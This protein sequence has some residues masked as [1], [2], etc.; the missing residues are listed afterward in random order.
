M[1]PQ[2]L[3]SMVPMHPPRDDPCSQNQTYHLP[4]PGLTAAEAYLGSN[5]YQWEWMAFENWEVTQA[6]ALNE[7]PGHGLP[8]DGQ[9]PISA[10]NRTYSLAQFGLCRP[11]R[12]HSL[13]F[14][15]L[16]GQAGF[17]TIGCSFSF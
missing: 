11:V 13:A 15:G 4:V 12:L 16:S 3:H 5:L 8:A 9:C 14:Q 17:C 2:L 1:G 6:G 10:S 7:I